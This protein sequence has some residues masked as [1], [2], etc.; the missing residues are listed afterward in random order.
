MPTR[1]NTVFLVL[2]AATLPL[3]AGSVRDIRRTPAGTLWA[4]GDGGLI[5][6]SDDDG[7]TWQSR[8][9]DASADLH[10]LWI[11]EPRVWA[12]GG[13]ATPAYPG[14]AGQAVILRSLDGGKTFESLPTGPA[15]W[16][17]GGA[18]SDDSVVLG[19]QP[20][21]RAPAGV[22]H[23]R[24]GGKRWTAVP[25]DGLGYL[26]GAAFRN[27]GYGYFVGQQ[28]RIVSLRNL[29][30]PTLHP[31]DIDSGVALT[32]AAFRDAE[33]C[34]AVGRRGTVVASRPGGQRWAQRSLPYPAGTRSLT[35]LEAI[36]FHDGHTCLIGGGLTG[37]LFRSGDTQRFE[38]LAAPGPGPVRC[39]RQLSTTD[40]LV[41]GDGGRIWR[42][43]DAGKTWQ[44]SRGPQRC[45][46][47]FIAAAGETSIYPAIVLHAAAGLDVAVVYVTAP[48]RPGNQ[49]EMGHAD[50]APGQQLRLAA[51]LAGAGGATV[52]EELPSLLLDPD[53]DGDANATSILQRWSEELD[54]PAEP[55]VL[56][57]LVAAIR[58]YRPRVVATGAAEPGPPGIAAENRLVAR[59]AARAVT[60]ASDEESFPQLL[61][62]K[63]PPHAAD[64]LFIGTDDNTDWRPP[65]QDTIHPARDAA[66]RI[67]ATRRPDG[68]SDSNIELLAQRAIW[69]IGAASLLDRPARFGT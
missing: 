6:T 30:Q 20:T 52:I 51:A 34:W 67:D 21:P 59:L 53:A 48:R 36:D 37:V 5:L 3:S 39:L 24:S 38:A 47:L 45:D 58:L 8:Q 55:E 4:V 33:T 54:A 60:L 46:V 7:R 63:L 68:E 19:G 2:A 61:G 56:R 42:S 15:G 18:A 65:W 27:F 10:Q 1:L 41:G 22:H 13:R 35:H 25:L 44:L 49:A 32:A 9:A 14:G 23:T 12:I 43:T 17:C 40:I 69:A 29:M 31:A 16:A 50:I 26:R 64:R 28:H 11:D 57:R 66:V 62:A